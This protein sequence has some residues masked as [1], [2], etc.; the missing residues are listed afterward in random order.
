METKLDSQIDQN[1]KL[2]DKEEIFQQ[3]V[4]YLQKK[5]A[6]SEKNNSEFEAII[7]QHKAK[8]Q[9]LENQKLKQ[10]DNRQQEF[11]Q[12]IWKLRQ[13]N[14]ILENKLKEFNDRILL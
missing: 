14:Y 11:N 2:K 5:L 8:R 6:Q 10:F 12:I 3:Q 13:D 4:K 1:K 9:E 7:A